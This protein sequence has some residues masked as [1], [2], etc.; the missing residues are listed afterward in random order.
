M[1]SAKDE[2]TAAQRSFLSAQ[3]RQSV[4]KIPESQA[5]HDRDGGAHRPRPPKP[6]VQR[7][8]GGYE[9]WL[10]RPIARRG[11]GKTVR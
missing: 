1:G 11:A 6:G 7:I 4:V 5:A 8:T 2:R 9:N 3:I 10:I